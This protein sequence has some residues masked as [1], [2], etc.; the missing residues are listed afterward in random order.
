M[1]AQVFGRKKAAWGNT[2]TR[3]Q[4]RAELDTAIYQLCDPGLVIGLFLALLTFFKKINLLNL[5]FIFGCDGS[6]YCAWAFSSCG[7]RG[8]LFVLVCR[9]LIGVASL[10]AEYGL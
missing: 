3:L 5:L 2:E 4:A 9:L 6:F 8:L 1:L 7:E 10:V